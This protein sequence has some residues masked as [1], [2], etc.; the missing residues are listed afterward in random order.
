ML[1][2][3]DSRLTYAA[4]AAFFVI[5]LGYALFEARGLIF[6]PRI[7]IPMEIARVE[8]P[9][10]EIAGK[11]ERIASLAMNG[12]PI[13]VTEDGDF[14]QT[15]VLAPG[16]NRITLDAADKY[17]RTSRKVIEIV[18][19]PPEGAGIPPT[20]IQDAASSTPEQPQEASSS[21]AVPR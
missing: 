11:A 4:L 1:P 7:S 12:Q 17:G 5:V 15:Y 8:D 21:P 19:A 18:Y 2:Y 6:G 16:Y 20:A 10:V 9:V 3:R 13:P 14:A